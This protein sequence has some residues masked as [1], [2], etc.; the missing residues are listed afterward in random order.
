MTVRAE[1]EEEIWK[2]IFSEEYRL[3]RV[4]EKLNEYRAVS[5]RSEKIEPNMCALLNQGTQHALF[6]ETELLCSV[7][8]LRIS[9]CK[10]VGEEVQRG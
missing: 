4:A 5:S 10:D 1:A 9:Q 3:R 2:W 8:Q 7:D 6:G